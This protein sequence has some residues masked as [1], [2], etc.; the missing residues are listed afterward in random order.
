M[1]RRWLVWGVIVGVIVL[2]QYL[3]VWTKTHMR[4]G[5][6][7]ALFDAQCCYLHFVENDGM[8]F[9]QTLGIPY[10]KFILSSFRI[11]AATALGFYLFS[12]LKQPQ[13]KQGLLICLSLIFAGAVGNIIDSTFY[14]MLFSASPGHGLPAVFWPE[15]TG[16][17]PFLHGK[18][19]DMFYFPLF[20]IQVPSFIPWLGGENL[21]FFSTVFNIADVAITLGVLQLLLFHR[22]FFSS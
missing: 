8:A 1:K 12:T 11:I 13:V 21:L 20:N 19:V 7:I 3:K 2:D 17:A 5:E 10:G 22:H 14:G 9:G 4:Y 15:S 6:M 16:Y 18:V